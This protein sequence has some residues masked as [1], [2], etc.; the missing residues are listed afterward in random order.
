MRINNITTNK[1]VTLDEYLD[2]GTLQLKLKIKP[3][4]GVFL[5][6]DLAK[7]SNQ[8]FKL[9]E[10]EVVTMIP[11]AATVTIA[12]LDAGVLTVTPDTDTGFDATTP[13]RA[14]VVASAAS[15]RVVVVNQTAT[16]FDLEIYDAAGALYSATAVD[17]YYSFGM[18]LERLY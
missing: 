11:T 15:V 6:D 12:V 2:T 14:V 16:T 3:G 1:T 9:Q 5:D 17:V 7:R 4:E 10:A 8:L 18:P 13:V